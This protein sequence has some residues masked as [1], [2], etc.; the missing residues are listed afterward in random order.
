MLSLTLLVGMMVPMAKQEQKLFRVGA[1]AHALGL[2]PMTLRRWI[3]EGCIQAVQVGREV[4]IPHLELERF[5]GTIDGRLRVFDGLVSGR[6][7]QVDLTTQLERLQAWAS[8]DWKGMETLLLSDIGS[9]LSAS[10]KQ[11][12]WLLKLIC[13]DK[14]A[15]IVIT[16][17][18]RLTRFGQEFLET[19][20][21]CFGVKLK[22]I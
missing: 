8:V 19:L 2:H 18:D 17:E 6:L 20:F 21:S 9:G 13:E 4:R 12:Q 5:V 16:Y 11:L 7:Q 1:T 14:V 15:E 3:K 22:V 10:R